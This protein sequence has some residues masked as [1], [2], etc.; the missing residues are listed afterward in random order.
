VLLGA[1]TTPV[2]DAEAAGTPAAT[3]AETLLRTRHAGTRVLVAEDEPINREV[4]TSLLEDAGCR[5]DTAANGTE[6]VAAARAAAYDVILMD[7][8][9]PTM[10]GTEA[11]QRIRADSRNRHTFIIATTANAFEDD[12]LACQAAGMDMHLPKPILPDALFEAVLRAVQRRG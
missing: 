6:A 7:M 9:M 11:T 12:Q 1:G 3:D 4:L 2:P 10:S 5:V 8:Q